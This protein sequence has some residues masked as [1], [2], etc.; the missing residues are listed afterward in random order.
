MNPLP[1]LLSLLALIGAAAAVASAQT[2]DRTPVQ[3][4]T[5]IESLRP[6]R[7][8]WREIRWIN[9]P[10]VALRLSREQKKPVIAWV[11]L[12]NPTDERC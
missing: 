12:G 1:T 8:A 6:E 3:L 11:F 5:E 10:L 9:C 2:P 7:L 4:K